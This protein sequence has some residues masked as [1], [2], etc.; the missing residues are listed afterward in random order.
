M[1]ICL[2][3]T[4]AEVRRHQDQI[5][6]VAKTRQA[7]ELLSSKEEGNYLFTPRESECEIFL[8]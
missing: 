6:R 4:E 2:S 7:A 1:A 8:S 5:D 3:E